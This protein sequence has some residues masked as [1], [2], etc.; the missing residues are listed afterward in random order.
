MTK[1][2]RLFYTLDMTD[3][4]RFHHRPIDAEYFEWLFSMLEGTGVTVLYR[5]NLAGR[6]YYPSR[7]M[8]PFDHACVDHDNPAAQYWHRVADMLDGLDPFA[9]AVRAA[10][11]HDV[12]VWAWWNWNEFQCIRRHVLY[13]VDPL[14]YERP[15]KYWCTRDGSRFYHGVPAFGDEDVR[16]RLLALARETLGYGVEGMYLSTRSHSWVPCFDAPDWADRL[17]DFGFNDC[18]VDAYRKRHGINIRFEDFDREALLRIK[19]EQFSTLLARTGTL[20]HDAGKPFVVGIYPDRTE[21]CAGFAQSG[22]EHSRHLEL[23]KDWEGW[24]AD[25]AVDGICS[26]RSCP[27]E[28]TLQAPD[29]DIFRK[30]LPAGFPIYAWVDTA[31]FCNRGFGAFHLGNWNR[32][33]VEDVMQQIDAAQ[34]AGAAGVFLH[35][36]YHFT[37]CD[38]AG[39]PLGGYG[40]LP[41]TEYLD[42]L[43][44]RMR[45]G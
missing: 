35:S 21:L 12:P 32:N 37:A 28:H 15:R 34:Q 18:V 9:E 4:P 19:G 1:P 33:S 23:Y 10:R 36:L 31:H 22:R 14:W 45:P 5:C 38:T 3:P 24:A 30:T 7:V 27:H 11:R 6:C 8:A 42:A 44:D 17:E 29:L 26:E 43:R 16:Q 20:A 2:F 25:G 13:L 40:V 39:E 41:R